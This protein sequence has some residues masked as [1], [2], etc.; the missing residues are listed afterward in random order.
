MKK[1]YE[2]PA[3]AV[4]TVI[5]ESLLGSDSGVGLGLSST[6]A[7]KNGTVYSPGQNSTSIWG[8]EE[9]E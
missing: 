4:V 8:D 3:V 6:D 7:D 5:T 1:R 2:K 9:D